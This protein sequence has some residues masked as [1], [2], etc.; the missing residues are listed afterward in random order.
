M[1]TF[2]SSFKQPSFLQAILE[3]FIDGVLILTDQGEWLHANQCAHRICHHLTE[4]MAQPDRVPQQIWRVCQSLIGSLSLY[5]NKAVV[6]EDEIIADDAAHYRLRAQ[7]VKLDSAERPCMLVTLEDRLQS[8]H[9]AAIAES[10]R[11]RLTPR[12]ADVW[13]RYRSHQTYKQIATA[14]YITPNTV[15]KHMKNIHAKRHQVLDEE[16]TSVPELMTV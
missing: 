16:V 4:G 2:T 7:W 14:L 3:S 5:P 1:E 13:L 9:D 10:Y 15:K 12:E 8:L 6:I 11:Y